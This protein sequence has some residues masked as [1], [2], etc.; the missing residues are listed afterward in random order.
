M[1]NDQYTLRPLELKDS[2][3]MLEWMRD[4]E[5]IRHLQIGGPNTTRESIEG[6]I[7]SSRVESKNLHRAVVNKADEYMGTVSLKH[8]DWE[9]G[10]AEYAIAM[11]RSALGSGAAF[12]ASEQILKIA[13]ERLELER[14]YLNVLQENRRA[15]RFYTKFGFHYTHES[16]VEQKNYKKI[17]FW[18]EITRNNFSNK[19][20]SI[21]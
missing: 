16:L 12:S 18:Y 6:F 10:E 9:K 1:A 11:H 17:L 7:L 14:V 20:D 19:T 8:I 3:R 5:I 15:I 2:E 4:P 21:N 13:F